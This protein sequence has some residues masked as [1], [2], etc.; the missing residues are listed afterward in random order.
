MELH[1]HNF[2]D[3]SQL[4]SFLEPLVGV[5]KQLQ[6][7]PSLRTAEASNAII[8]VCRDLQG[9]V[10]GAAEADVYNVVFR[11]LRPEDTNAASGLAGLARAAE[12][13]YDNPTVIK[14]VLKL[15][16]ELVYDNGARL[17]FHLHSP[18]GVVLFRESC[19]ILSSFSHKAHMIPS[20]DDAYANKYKTARL[21]FDVIGFVMEGKY[22]NFGVMDFYGDTT[23]HNT[24]DGIFRLG[25][26][27]PFADM[28]KFAKV[29]LAFYHFVES[30]F[31][32]YLM[33]VVALESQLFLSLLKGL[34]DGLACTS[35]PRYVVLSA[36]CLDQLA[37]FLF[38]NMRKAMPA[39]DKLRAHLSQ[40]P[41]AFV[42]LLEV[43]FNKLIFDDQADVAALSQAILTLALADQDS[44][45]TCSQR[46][47]S[48]QGS[49]VQPQMTAAFGTLT[50]SIKMSLS[51]EDRQ[52]FVGSLDD[53]RKTVR[54]TFGLGLAGPADGDS[55]ADPR[56]SMGSMS[57]AV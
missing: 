3:G 13:L 32:N 40:A 16:M 15:V 5:L 44:F 24:L 33:G 42:E 35:D 50:A 54:T 26:S 7:A 9:V 57:M 11:C 48:Q 21:C 29:G 41:G 51:L 34:Q 6:S 31:R 25:L 23:L 20:G 49:E 4:E 19:T 55:E 28:Q 47:S 10:A 38:Q 8:G 27:I 2:G 18:N 53:F 52:E 30:L 45:V 39:M 17:A 56:M 43:L 14:A 22:V 46:I 36:S 12:E 1:L 37:T